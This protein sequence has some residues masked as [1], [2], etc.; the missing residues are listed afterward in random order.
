MERYRL[1]PVFLFRD[2]FCAGFQPASVLA[3][4]FS[5]WSRIAPDLSRLQPD[6]PRIYHGH[7]TNASRLKPARIENGGPFVHRLKPVALKD[8]GLKP[9][10][11]QHV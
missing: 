6:L 10:K 1:A 8:A 5:R 7:S 11:I 3:T 2:G 9:A 4:G